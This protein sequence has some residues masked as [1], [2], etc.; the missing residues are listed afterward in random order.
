MKLFVVTLF[1]LLPGSC[2]TK[3]TLTTPPVPFTDVLTRVAKVI[4]TILGSTPPMALAMA[5]AMASAAD[6][7]SVLMACTKPLAF[8][9]T[10]ISR[11]PVK[12]SKLFGITVVVIVVVSLVLVVVL[13]LVQKGPFPEKPTVSLRQVYTVGS[14]AYEEP[15]Y[16]VQFPGGKTPEQLLVSTCEP[17]TRG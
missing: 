2:T 5:A 9:D 16:T 4:R 17:N 8:D 11:D 14:P 7:E 1:G 6:W 10:E 15:Q 12:T 3:D 13:V